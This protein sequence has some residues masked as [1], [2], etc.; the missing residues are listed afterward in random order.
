MKGAS[1]NSVV[2]DTAGNLFVCQFNRPYTISKFAPNGTLLANLP[3]SYAVQ[4]MTI[5]P[6]NNL[7]IVPY[8]AMVNQPNVFKLSSVDGHLIKTYN[9]QAIAVAVDSNNIYAITSDGQFLSTP[10]VVTVYDLNGG[11]VRNFTT[12]WG[13]NGIA[14]D[15]DGNIYTGEWSW[16]DK[17][18]NAGDI[19][20]RL[21]A[22]S[23]ILVPGDIAIDPTSKDIFVADRENGR[24]VQ[25]A[26]ESSTVNGTITHIYSN[27]AYRQSV[28]VAIEPSTGNVFGGAYVAVV[29]YQ[30]P[31]F[32]SQLFAFLSA[33]F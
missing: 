3:V 28:G 16:L 17:R 2:F 33:L 7:F 29:V 15:A 5:D 4:R 19:I 30:Q 12:D 10:G 27:S 8:V 6:D 14:V 1:V 20:K 21:A 23:P 13:L 31:S 18:N 26:A 11:F 24:I 32:L 25:W 22:P 9:I